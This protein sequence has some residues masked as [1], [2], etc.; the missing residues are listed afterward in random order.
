M[1]KQSIWLLVAFLFMSI[2]LAACQPQGNVSEET[3]A[4]DTE[5]E[6][7]DHPLAGKE[8]ALIMQINLG[9]FSA[10]Y[11]AGVEEQ[12]ERFG[13]KATVFTSEGDLAKMASNL[14][15][16]INQGV[17]GILIDHG[18]KEA[19]NQGVE[20]ALEAGIPVVAFDTGIEVEGVVSLEQGDQQMAEMTLDKLA[21]D[22]GGQANIVKIW[23]AGF[24]P[25]ER[26][27]IAYEK[28]LTDNPGIKEVTAFGAATNNTA[29]D[30]QSQMEAV[31]KQYPNEGEITAVWASWDEF[32][33]GAVRAIEQAGRTDI[34]VY[35]I[36]MSDEDLQLMQKEGSPWLASAAVDPADIGRIQVRYLY[37]L[38][39]GEQPEEKVILEPVFVEAENLPEEAVTT[40][41]LS[42]YVEGW[43]A[44]DQGYTDDLREL[45]DQ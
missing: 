6:V 34:K 37:Q 1:K 19:L 43:G 31:L 9:T 14:D 4:S 22:Y 20:K 18:T 3:T 45:E 39:N 23:T 36:D 7:S 26:R 12:V 41:E 32:A 15:A 25:M 29:L 2:L 10:Q 5:A 8:I 13:G 24:A 11:I 44:S 35:G 16:A 21:E 42:E 28:F 40:D 33:K 38:L 27:Q 30:T 17:D